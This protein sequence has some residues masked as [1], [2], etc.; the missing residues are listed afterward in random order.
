MKKA[1]TWFLMMVMCFSLVACGGN[2]D[3]DSE[4]TGNVRQEEDEKND[5]DDERDEED[6]SEK[7]STEMENET[8][9][10]EPENVVI[11]ED[12]TPVIA[13]GEVQTVSDVCEFYVD[14]VNMSKSVLPP[15]PGDW[16]SYYE[17]ENGKIYVDVCVSYKNLE[18]GDAAAD[19]VVGGVLTYGGK[20]EYTGFSIIEK[21][22]RSDFT[23]T[24]ITSIAPLST[25]YVHY[26]FELPEEAETSGMAM[27][28]KLFVGGEKYK[29]IFREGTEGS[30]DTGSSAAGKTSGT[31]VSGE[32]IAT[33]D[34]EFYVDFAEIKKSVLPPQPGDWYSYYEAESGKV[35]VDLC[36][37]YKN[38]AGNDVMADEVMSGKLQYAGKYDYT[39]FSIIEKESRTDFTYSN[40]TSIAPLSTEYVHYLFEVPEEVE[41]SGESVVIS[42]TIDGNTYTYTVR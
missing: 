33:R 14:Y 8:V 4:K 36:V 30:A 12:K 21:E 38:L 17:A 13:I 19:E 5:E 28:I 35:Y 37:A 23:Y 32:V 10:S 42:F 18:T 9:E 2:G 39:G 24:N 34:A 27:E 40:I 1:V 6:E 26:L 15:Q 7:E 11:V 41:S 22:S 29:L 31:V 25:E 16:Y 20:Y 3:T